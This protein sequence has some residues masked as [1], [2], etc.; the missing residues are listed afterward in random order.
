MN[1]DN[2]IYW[3]SEYKTTNGLPSWKWLYDNENGKS[4]YSEYN[5][6]KI[7]MFHI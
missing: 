3:E 5:H 2:L 6:S 1:N 7:G 4:T